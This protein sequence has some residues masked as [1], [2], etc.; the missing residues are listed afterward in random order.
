MKTDNILEIDN[1]LDA[2]CGEGFIINNISQKD[3]FQM[4]YFGGFAVSAD[5][6][7][8]IKCWRINHAQTGQILLQKVFVVGKAALFVGDVETSHAIGI[9]T[10]AG[11]DDSFFVS[12]HVCS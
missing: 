4:L 1:I 5:R 9:A 3:A 8:A 6:G 2:G 12:T 7:R 10:N 11:P